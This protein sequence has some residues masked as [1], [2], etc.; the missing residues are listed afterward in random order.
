M[1]FGIGETLGIP[2]ELYLLDKSGIISKRSGH[3]RDE[4]KLFGCDWYYYR[5]NAGA[6][7]SRS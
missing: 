5:G 3:P 1:N 4:S 2:V 7:T 6:A